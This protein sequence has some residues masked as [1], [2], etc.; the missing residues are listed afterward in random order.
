MIRR[1]LILGAGLSITLIFAAT[2]VS[3]AD[4]GKQLSVDGFLLQN[5]LRVKTGQYRDLTLLR[6]LKLATAAYVNPDLYITAKVTY[7]Y[8]PDLLDTANSPDL[9]K[10][11]KEGKVWLGMASVDGKSLEVSFPTE[12]DAQLL[13]SV[14]STTQEEAKL[15]LNNLFLANQILAREVG[16]VAMLVSNDQALLGDVPNDAYVAWS[17]NAPVMFPK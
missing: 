11:I 15:I 10:A 17:P 12:A 9:L 14:P 16:A 1:D 8:N 13:K 6:Q 4:P 3:Q 5:N 7:A 2:L